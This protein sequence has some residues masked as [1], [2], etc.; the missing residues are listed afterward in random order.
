MKNSSALKTFSP[1]KT[2][3]GWVGTGV[4]GL[5]MCAHLLEAGCQVLV[6][7]R[8]KSKAGQLLNSGAQWVDS[9]KQAAQ[10]AD[11]VFTIVGFPEDVRQVY[12][13]P[14]GILAGLDRNRI[15]VDLTTTSPALAREISSQ[16]SS[17][18]AFAL[19][20][21]VSGGDV[22]ARRGCLSIMVGGDQGVYDAVLPL[23]SLM[24]ENI[25]HQGPAG[26]GQH[27]KM[28]N[29]IVIAGTMIGVCESLVYG[30]AAGLDLG[31]MLQ[32]IAKGAAGCWSLDNLAPRILKEDF[33]PGFMVDHFVKDMGLALEESAKMGINLPG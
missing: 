19:D 11:V 6:F 5:H 30:A 4:M 33:A 22:G 15:C 7:N 17:R 25:I 18:Q 32:S 8:T 29:Q 31:R 3:V 13:S 14:D 12:F 24:G 20:A 26:A 2:V 27:T 23:L 16:A 28:C 9:P 10:E 21:P 1:E